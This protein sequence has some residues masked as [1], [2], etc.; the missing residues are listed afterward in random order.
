MADIALQYHTIMS[1][2]DSLNTAY[3][4]TVSQLNEL[5]TK[6]DNLV[7]ADGGLW[8]NQTSPV[9]QVVY[10]NFSSSAVMFVE[11]FN[12]FAGMF[13][14]LVTGMESSDYKMAYQLENPKAD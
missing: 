13:Q 8:M 10:D 12:N 11:N 6:V 7:T 3:N 4:N 1:V 14:N 5:R 2:H 9:I